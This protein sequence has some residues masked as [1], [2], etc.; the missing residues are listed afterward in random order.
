MASVTT[1]GDCHWPTQTDPCNAHVA[2]VDAHR[3]GSGGPPA[4]RPH[5]DAS[6][7]SL[8]TLCF[9]AR[10][11]HCIIAY[12]RA[13]RIAMLYCALLSLMRFAVL[14]LSIA[15]LSGS[16]SSDILRGVVLLIGNCG[17]LTN[18]F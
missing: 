11:P 9:A 12:I 5:H 16:G 3:R 10:F 15:L 18:D 17:L 13:C 14:L 4:G 7:L 6:G 1:P 8:K 2:L